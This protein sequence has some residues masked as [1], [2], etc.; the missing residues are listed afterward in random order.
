M[1]LSYVRCE[2]LKN[3]LNESLLFILIKLFE[4]IIFLDVFFFKVLSLFIRLFIFLILY[5]SSIF[6]DCFFLFVLL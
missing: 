2:T 6:F 3:D 4:S 5:I 1:G